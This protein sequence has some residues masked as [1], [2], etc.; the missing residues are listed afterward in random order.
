MPIH[1]L[2]V[3]AQHLPAEAINLLLEPAG[4]RLVDAE[5]GLTNWDEVAA[6]TSGLTF[7]ICE[8]RADGIIDHI[9][10]AKLRATARALA[11]ALTHVAEEG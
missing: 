11:A 2:L 1:G 6:Q 10:T 4:K 3:L 7:E 8:A 5:R 9:E